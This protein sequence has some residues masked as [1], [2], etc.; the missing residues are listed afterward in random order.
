MGLGVS[1]VFVN[2]NDISFYVDSMM[3]GLSMV[4]GITERGPVAKAVFISSWPKFVEVFGGL[5]PHS[6]FP[7]L[8]QRALARGAA[9]WVSRIAH[10]EDVTKKNTITA[11]AAAVI[12]GGVQFEA[13]SPGAWGNDLK[14]QIE[15]HEAGEEKL[16][17]V[18]F[19]SENS[20]LSTW[21]DVTLEEMQ[22]LADDYITARCVAEVSESKL[23]SGVYPLTGGDDG[24]SGLTDADF[25]GDEAAGTG[26]HVFD[27]VDDGSLQLAAP[28]TT[29]FAVA[30][31][32]HAYCESR[33]DL[34]YV[35]AVPKGLKPQEAVDYRKGKLG[36]D[37]K[38][39]AP[40]SL[41]YGA[42][43]YPHL[44][45]LDLQTDETRLINPTG[46]ILGVFA[47]SDNTSEEWFAAAGYKRGKIPNCLGVEYNVGARAR[48]QEG[49]LLIENQ[50][51][52][53]CVFEDVGTVVWGNETLQQQAS[54]LRDIHTR[55]LLLVLKKGMAKSCRVNLFDP[56]DPTLWRRTYNLLD[57]YLRNIQ[58]R[59][60]F[61]DYRLECDQDAQSIDEAKINTAKTVEK[62]EFHVRVWIKPMKV[63][64]WIIID[65]NILKTGAV[66]ADV[67]GEV[68]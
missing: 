46:D 49:G 50:I 3:K 12:V 32:G 15:T 36:D 34:F 56:N 14:V 66:F 38:N 1:D 33:G 47:Y 55:R 59:R 13:T 16:Y 26:F 23:A 24:I 9:L 17:D 21:Q 19:Y 22:A 58:E 65:M 60:G 39:S 57:P 35:S 11:R 8:C 53:I 40:F 67:L 61:Y 20:R 29:S 48:T 4:E 54:A 7:L 30:M 10:Y 62:G 2:E 5:V 64:K 63:A 45:V 44:N 42:L 6:D 25:I 41:N 31:A 27:E 43:Y 18:S 52:P 68:V 51:N 28:D 37:L